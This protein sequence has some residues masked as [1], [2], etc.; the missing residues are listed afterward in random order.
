MKRNIGSVFVLATV[1]L[2]SF[3]F[4][5]EVLANEAG[6][7]TAFSSEANTTSEPRSLGG[8][9]PWEFVK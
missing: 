7:N 1:V 3:A 9:F 5:K 8:R 2:A 6:E 4:E